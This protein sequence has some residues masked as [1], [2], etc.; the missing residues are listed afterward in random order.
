[1]KTMNLIMSAAL[2]LV[3][4]GGLGVPAFAQS[5]DEKTPGGN[6][7][8]LVSDHA[9]L[10]VADVSKEAEWYIRVL[11]FH[12]TKHV[13]PRP[14]FEQA[15]VD[16]DGY[17]LDLVRQAGSTRPPTVKPFFQQGYLHIVFRTTTIDA[18]YARL[19]SLGV[20]VAVGGRN[21]KTQAPRLLTL[22]DPE[23]NEIEI[24]AATTP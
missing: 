20:E 9:T 18:V 17:H 12:Q 23:G 10:S 8:N 3:V 11:G 16:I 15:V 1:M 6:P 5:T 19:K 24:L 13:Q 22:Y 21:A 14:D 2:L 7:L 4:A